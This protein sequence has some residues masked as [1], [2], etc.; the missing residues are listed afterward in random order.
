MDRKFWMNI[1]LIFDEKSNMINQ[2]LE[3]VW[4]YDGKKKQ[5]KFPK[6]FISPF[7]KIPKSLYHPIDSQHQSQKC[8]Y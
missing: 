5:F 4:N 2:E 7:V 3:E 8:Y 6:I 1:L